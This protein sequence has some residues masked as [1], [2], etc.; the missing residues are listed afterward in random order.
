MRC[1]IA[2]L[3]EPGLIRLLVDICRCVRQVLIDLDDISRHRAEYIRHSLH[4]LHIRKGLAGLHCITALR[5]I[6]E[7]Q[8]AELMLCIIRKADKYCAIRL[9]FYPFM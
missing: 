3:H 7:D 8:I 6:H 1:D 9:F 4:R 5:H 2:D